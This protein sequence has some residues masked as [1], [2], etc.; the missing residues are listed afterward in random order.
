MIP[1][2]VGQLPNADV[3]VTGVT[4]QTV[5]F[6][7]TLDSHV[8]YVFAFVLTMAFLL[9]LVTFRSIVIPVTA[10]VL[11]LLSVGA[12]YGVLVLIFQDGRFESFLGYQSTGA[13]ASWLPLFLFVVLF[14]LS[15]DYHVFILTR[16]REGYDNGLDTAEAV[17]HGIKTTAGVVTSAAAIMI[18]VFAIFAT[19]SALEF[20]QVGVG[21]SVAVLLDATI[22]R[23]V[24]LPS[25][26]KLMGKWNWYLPK[27][28]DWLPRVTPERHGP[29]SGARNRS[30]GTQGRT[31]FCLATPTK[32][33]GAKADP[34]SGHE[35]VVIGA[36]QAGLAT[37]EGV[38]VRPRASVKG[39]R[40]GPGPKPWTR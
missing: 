18:A 25:V 16:V 23:G 4:A 29:A 7:S 26:M 22:V 12:A 31:G 28:L 3:A 13:I 36:G 19:L 38:K 17:S 1:A 34:A 33:P 35:I 32:I 6:N 2:T 9:L 8:R 30:H 39:V 11:N 37:K 10:I 15:M 21:L 27:S 14:G 40:S 5:D 20:K 24:L